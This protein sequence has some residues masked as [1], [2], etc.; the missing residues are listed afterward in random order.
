MN[1]SY[2]SS[3]QEWTKT[4][5]VRLRLLRTKTLLGHLMHVANEDPTV[6]RR[7]SDFVLAEIEYTIYIF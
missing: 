3:L 5:N 1:F 4:T 2:S 7:V 6:T